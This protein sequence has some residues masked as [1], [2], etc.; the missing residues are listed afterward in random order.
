[1]R[2]TFL[3]LLSIF[4]AVSAQG[5]GTVPAFQV[6]LGQGTYTLAGRDPAKR[7][8]TTIPTVLVP[9]TLSF[10]ARKIAG[11]PFLEAAPEVPSILRS[12]VFSKFD[13]PS[14]GVTQYADAMLRTTFP[15]ANGWHTLLGEPE[16]KRIRINIPVGSG[17]VLTS[18]RTGGSL[19]IV[20]VDFLQQEIFKTDSQTGRHAGHCHDPEHRLLRA[21]RRYGVLFLGNARCRFRHWKFLRARLVSPCCPRNYRRCRRAASHATAS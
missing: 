14:G 8:V 7:G 13:F 19:A 18:K 17:Y 5:A 21:W 2:I 10:D 1:M 4:V 3:C 16:V 15:K 20:D 12:P 6:T 9:I 11:K